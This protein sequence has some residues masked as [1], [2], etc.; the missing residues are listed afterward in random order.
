MLAVPDA[1]G[2]GFDL[3]DEALRPWTVD[4]WEIAAN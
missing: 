2:L 1:P 4:Q 3:T